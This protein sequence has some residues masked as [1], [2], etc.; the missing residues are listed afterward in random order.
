MRRIGPENPG[1]SRFWAAR[2]AVLVMISFYLA[3]AT[4]AAFYAFGVNPLATR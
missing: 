1:A 2:A 3:G 4:L